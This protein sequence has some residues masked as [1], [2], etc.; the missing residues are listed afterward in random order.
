MCFFFY[1]KCFHIDKQ[2][3]STLVTGMLIVAQNDFPSF[4]ADGSDICFTDDKPTSHLQQFKHSLLFF[5]KYR[6][7]RFKQQV[8]VAS[9]LMAR[10]ACLR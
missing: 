5:G 2:S 1:V 9:L 8:G 6:D 3:D 4:K 10:A 7:R